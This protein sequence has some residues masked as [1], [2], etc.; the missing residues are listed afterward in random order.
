M[1]E[2]DPDNSEWSKVLPVQKIIAEA[3]I[4][5]RDSVAEIGCGRKLHRTGFEH[6]QIQKIREGFYFI[7]AKKEKLFR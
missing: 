6:I 4:Q 5:S 2:C 1:K 7:T 3:G